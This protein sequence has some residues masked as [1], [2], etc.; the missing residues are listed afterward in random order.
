M[1]HVERKLIEQLPKTDLHCHLDGSPRIET[2]IELA[3]KNNV[4]LPSYEP[5]TLMEKMKYGRVRSTL[6]EYL[7]GFEPIIAIMQEADDI[8]RVF[9]EVCE[10]A[11]L[12]N[13]W[14]LELRYCPTL[15]TRK[16]LTAKE[17]VQACNRGRVRAQKDFGMSVVQILCGLKND[18]SSSIFEIAKLVTDCRELGVVGFDLAGPE[19]G[20]PIR[21][22]LQAIFWA[23]KHHTFITLHA[24]EACG[25]ESIFEAIHDASCHRIGH[26][27]SLIK[28]DRIF[29][30]VVN[31]RIGVESCPI[32]NWHTGSVK[33]LD[34]HPIKLFLERGVRVSINTDN[35]LC[36]DTSVTEEI[37]AVIEHL[38]L[39]MKHVRKLLLNGFKSAFL[40]FEIK[41]RMI[42]AFNIEWAKIV[43]GVAV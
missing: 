29:D 26:G 32:S 39:S 15:L 1:K 34:E 13:V 5:E 33:S 24:G 17:V 25:P 11:S 10:D 19:K 6:E 27:T 18:P 37:L 12:E 42:D 43:N 7:M 16:G 35:R 3:K 38:D 22:H 41:T 21:D 14:H 9:Y 8:E 36:S 23:K 20:F 31:H 2:L 4:R 30:Y 40:P 28:D